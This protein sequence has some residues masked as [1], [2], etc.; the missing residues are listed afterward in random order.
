MATAGILIGR[1]I[2]KRF[3]HVVEAIGGFGL[4]VIGAKILIEHTLIR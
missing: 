4:I 2:G 3:G 1:F